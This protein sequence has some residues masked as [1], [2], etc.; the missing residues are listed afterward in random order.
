LQ[1]ATLHSFLVAAGMGN[2]TLCMGAEGCVGTALFFGKR[3]TV[4]FWVAGKGISL[5][6]S[7]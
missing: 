6:L 7:S 1:L 4:T 2:A 3:L 5:A